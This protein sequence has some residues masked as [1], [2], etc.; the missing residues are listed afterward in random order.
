[1]AEILR[2]EKITKTFPGIIALNKMSFDVD[3]GEIHA[4]C[5]ENG[6]GKSTLMK[7]I[8]AVHK[9]DS[10]EIFFNGELQNFKS[11]DESLKKGISII[12]QE[13]SLF[14]EM[15]VLENL[16][17]AHELD[18]KVLGILPIINYKE[19]SQ[20]AQEIIDRLGF[21][22]NVNSRIKDLGMAQ[23]QM[24]EIAKA[25]TFNAKVLIL[26]EPTASLT[27]KE[28]ASL[29]TIIR[30]LKQEGVAVIYISHR[31]EEIF[32]LCDRVTVIRDGKYISTKEVNQTN[33]DQLVADMVGRSMVNYF[34]KEIVD[35]GK[36][37]LRVEGLTQHNLLRN[38]SFHINKG[39]I[40]GFAGLAGAGRTEVAQAICGLT[41]PDFGDIYLDREK[42]TNKSYKQAMEHGLVYV[43]E[44]RAKYGLVTKMKIKENISMPQLSKLSKK[45]FIN[46]KQEESLADKY[47]N[48]IGIKTPNASFVTENLSGGNQ[49]KV[50]VAKALAVVPKL[51]ILDEPTRGVDVGAKAEIHK[52]ISEMV[53]KGLT[54]LLISSEITELLGLCDRIYIM[55][56][57]EIK[58]CLDRNEASQ[59]KILKIALDAK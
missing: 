58:G 53:K 51:F 19:M 9:Q 37:V 21:N 25:L 4:I 59:E 55:K 8:T 30:K 28:V 50:S 7:V 27:A 29:F 26:D 34:P 47:I 52:V 48:D 46:F 17:M 56:E 12:Y 35:I 32:E 16:Y 43:S 1:M 20:K 41:T 5:G 15:T 11:P 45:G 44:D 18:K 13:T 2:L 24:V 10:G 39:E 31:L 6:A 38:I 14:A 57:G 40:V 22:L 54:L 3:A 42:I 33:K 36:E 49:Q 23:K